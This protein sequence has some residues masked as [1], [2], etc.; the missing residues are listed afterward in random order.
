MV[1]WKK[2]IEGRELKLFSLF[3]MLLLA[4]AALAWEPPAGLA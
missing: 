2:R 1:K 3:S 4:V